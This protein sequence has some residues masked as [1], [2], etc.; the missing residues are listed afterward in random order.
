[1]QVKEYRNKT[2]DDMA[3]YSFLYIFDNYLQPKFI[4]GN[5][6]KNKII[7]KNNFV[8]IM[9]KLRKKQHL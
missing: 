4:A 7:T 5:K 9:R 6:N 1:M 3:Y 8:D 2:F